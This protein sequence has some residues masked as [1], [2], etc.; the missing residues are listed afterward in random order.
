MTLT[1]TPQRY[2]SLSIGLHWLMALLIIAVYACIELRELYP[3]GSDPR[4]M[5][6]TWH[7]M[8]GLTVFLL[9]WLRLA[10]NLAST[11][12][13]IV[14]APPAWQKTVAAV[15]H[16]LLYVMMLA[17]PLGGWLMLSA[18]GK[19]IPFFGME[20]PPLIG[21]NESLAK[22]I[23]EIHTTAGEAGYFL[24]ALHTGAALFHHHV[25]RDNTLVRMLP[26]RK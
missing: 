5:L 23:K 7:F 6:K 11:K 12:P 8:L 17:L 26:Q 20:L 19:P 9:A 21:E 4:E 10:V 3:K 25:M 14:P 18:A 15:A 16:V 22:I 13:D 2:G 24:I 1:N